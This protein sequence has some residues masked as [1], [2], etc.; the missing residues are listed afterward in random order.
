M[1]PLLRSLEDAGH[2]TG[3]LGAPGAPLAPLLRDHAGRR[4]GARAPARG[5]RAAA[6]RRSRASVER[7][8]DAIER[9][10]EHG[11]DAVSRARA[12]IDIAGRAVADRPR[13]SGTTRTRWPSFV[14]GL[15]HVHAVEGDYPRAGRGREVGVVPRRAR[16][17]ARAGR[18]LRT[19]R[20]ARSSTS[21]TRRSS[22][23]QTR[24]LRRTL[25]DGVR[26]DRAR[27][28]VRD[29]ATAGRHAA[30]RPAVRAPRPGRLAA[31]HARCA[32]RA[33]SR[34]SASS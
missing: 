12:S 3:E 29:Q 23:R 21:R 25:E 11:A 22:G 31:A 6:G 13:R 8:R 10:A 5:R 4:G 27:A 1:Y 33:S 34:P 24:A 15:K 7:L 26:R 32:S 18:R 28:R 9:G 30:R 19:A 14:D 2:V 16:A 20:G 17:R